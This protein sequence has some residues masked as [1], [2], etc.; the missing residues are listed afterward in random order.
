MEDGFRHP[1]SSIF[2][3]RIVLIAG[4]TAVGKSEIALCLAERVGGDFRLSVRPTPLPLYHPLARMS[5]DEMGL[6]YYTDTAGIQTATSNE[7]S[8]VP[9]AAAML[10]DIIQIGLRA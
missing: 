3:S 10:R 7:R 2:N 4:P 9:T 6:V 5:D 1:Q 8:A